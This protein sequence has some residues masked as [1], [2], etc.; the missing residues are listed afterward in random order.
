[1]DRETAL[2]E[3]AQH[4]EER[5]QMLTEFFGKRME[6]HL[7]EL[8][9]EIYE[10]IA[11]PARIIQIQVMRTDVYQGR[12]QI[13]VCGYDES[14]YM[15]EDH[16]QYPVEARYLYEPFAAEEMR[17]EK[18]ISV[19]MGAVTHYDIKNLVCEHFIKC[20]ADQAVRVRNHFALFDEW[21]DGQGLEIPVPYRILWGTYRGH[22]ETLFYMDKIHKTAEDLKAQLKK[23]NL[24][25][26]FVESSVADMEI[27]QKNFAFL[28]MK[29]SA[30]LRVCFA[31]CVFG[32]SMFK[33]ALIEWCGFQ[34]CMFY[35]CN[36]NDV[37]GY[38]M[39][40]RGA[41]ITNT[42]Y[43]QITLRKG[44]F[45]GAVLTDVSFY[46]AAL[47][48]CSFQNA[49]LTR[50]DLR[51]EAMENIDFT[52]ATLQDVYVHY[53]DADKLALTEEQSGQV[54]VLEEETDE[55]L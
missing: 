43:E 3:L 24:F 36:F 51:A 34:K 16:W 6:E 8:I 20:F 13:M 26:S 54:Y 50:V 12:S 52:G 2:K 48:E 37:K 10:K 39:D 19:Y 29:K 14:W 35:G 7:E 41:Q 27:Q 33:E 4:F 47:E 30:L 18:E 40:F 45:E 31:Q 21:A 38:Q 53:K 42:A 5:K 23:D 22:A 17:L 55:V 9:R 49:T 44:S 15:D 46:G 32:Q 25:R 1:M 28:N 11:H